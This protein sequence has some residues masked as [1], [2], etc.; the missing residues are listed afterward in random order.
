MSVQSSK[1]V[2][3]IVPWTLPLKPFTEILSGLL[4]SKKRKSTIGLLLLSTSL[5]ISGCAAVDLP[6]VH[7]WITLPASGDCY[8][9]STISHQKKRLPFNSPECENIKRRSIGFMSEDWA[10]LRYTLLKNC[11]SF[12]CKQSVG[13][14]DS[15]FYA[16]D[17]A[18]KHIPSP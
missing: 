8:S 7:A 18:L 11:L 17:D 10:K 12:K 5:L 14:L 2:T 16:V 13:A 9:M 6:D 4:Q 1:K 15:L 3:S